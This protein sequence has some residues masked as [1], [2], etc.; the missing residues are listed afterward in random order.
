MGSTILQMMTEQR[1]LLIKEVIILLTYEYSATSRFP[2]LVWWSSH[3]GTA[4]IPYSFSQSNI[5]SFLQQAYLNQ[6]THDS[7]VVPTPADLLLTNS[8]DTRKKASSCVMLKNSSSFGSSL[9]A[10][11]KEAERDPEFTVSMCLLASPHPES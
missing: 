4:Y 3:C 11:A 1:T 8:R 6:D 2:F 9:P 10:I 5:S 7:Q